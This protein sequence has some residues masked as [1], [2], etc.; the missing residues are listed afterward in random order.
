MKKVDV[1]ERL[2][3]AAARLKAII[4][5]VFLKKR[6]RT[7]RGH[8]VAKARTTSGNWI[9]CK[10]K[11][12]ETDKI[13]LTRWGKFLGIF[14]YNE[15]YVE[16]EKRRPTIYI[17]L[18]NSK[19]YDYRTA[20]KYLPLKDEK[21][22]VVL[23][24]G[25]NPFQ[26]KLKRE[27]GFQFLSWKF[28]KPKVTT[29]LVVVVITV[30]VILSIYQIMGNEKIKKEIEELKEAT[31]TPPAMCMP[32][33]SCLLPCQESCTLFSEMCKGVGGA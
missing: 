4:K 16:Y 27:F 6:K 1:K 5:K 7:V 17:D 21:G 13:K 31:L 26:P 32:C 10:A 14:D 22:K 19:P 11:P 33:E 9:K 15:K 12:I 23:E 25:V 8:L 2:E 3:K 20:R 29:G 18:E 28:L 24:T 30:V